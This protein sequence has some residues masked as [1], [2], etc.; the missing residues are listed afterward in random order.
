[1]D[2]RYNFQKLTPVNDVE[3]S[4]YKNALDF[5]FENPAIKNVGISGA[6]SAG[7]S[8]VI[9]TY[10]KLKPDVKFM[11]ISLAYF[12]SASD[13]DRQPTEQSE[14]V[15]EG[16]ILN[17]L[18][19]QI[20]PNKIPQTNFR[21]KRQLSPQKLWLSTAMVSLFTLLIIYLLNFGKWGDFVKSLTTKFLNQCLSFTTT[22]LTAFLAGGVCIAILSYLIYQII[23]VQFN[24]NLFKGIS[25]QG[26]TIEIFEQSEESYFDKYLN[27]VLYLFENS[28]K[29]VIVFED[30][31]RYNTNQI[32]Q[33]LREINTLVNS[34]KKETYKPLRFFYLLRD[35]IFINKER[36][37]FF[38]FIMP[39]VPILDGS[40]SF[41]QF[42]AHFKQ[43]NI[44]HLFNE[45]FLQ[46]ISLYIDDM[47]IL[48]NI[49]NEF[50]IYYKRISTTEQDPNRL[51]AIII[52]KNIF[53]RD[54]SE[55]QLNSGYVYTL[56]SK[57]D[58]FIKDEI[59][60][61][62]EE[63]SLITKTI[64]AAE[65]EHLKSVEEINDLFNPKIQDLQRY[66]NRQEQID[67]LNKE[68][69]SRFENLENKTAE[70]KNGLNQEISVL[71]AS[72]TD[73]QHKK[74]HEIINRQN[75]ERIFKV[76]YTNEIGSESTFNDIKGSDYFAL[77]KYL[78]KYGYIDETYP[79]YMTYFYE[80]S[81]SRIDKIFLRSVTDEDAKDYTY[82]LKSPEMVLARLS[83]TSFDKEEVLNFDLLAYLLEHQT[84]ANKNKTLKMLLQ[85]KSGKN[86]KFI[87][88][89]FGSQKRI[90]PFIKPLNN[91]WPD[92]FRAILEESNFTEEQKKAYA[93][94][95]IYHTAPAN[96]EE[97][98]SE[99]AL[100]NFVS[101]HKDFLDIAEPDIQRLIDVFELLNIKFLNINYEQ[102]NKELFQAVYQHNC[103]I[104]SYELV[105]LML[106]QIYGCLEES[107]LKHKNYTVVLSRINEPL[108]GYVQENINDYVK[109]ILKHC[110]GEILD[111]EVTAIKL[112]ND[113][114]LEVPLKFNYIDKLKTTICSLQDIEDTTLW[115]KLI[116]CNLIVYSESNVLKYFCCSGNDLD[117]T[118]ATFIN[119]KGNSFH[120][121]YDAIDSEFEKGGGSK[122]FNA[123]VKSEELSLKPY[124]SIL[125]SLSRHYKSFN[126]EGISDPKI[127]VLIDQ[128][129]ITMISQVLLFMRE[130][131]PQKIV[132]F[133]KHNIQEYTE[134][135]ISAENFSFDEM[136]E[137]LETNVDD[138]YKLSLLQH[139]D[140]PISAMVDAY[141]DEVKAYILKNNF[142]N[143]DIPKLLKAYL[144]LT[145]KLQAIVEDIARSHIEEIIENEYFVP[146]QL[147]QILFTLDSLHDESKLRLFAI[148]VNDFN[149]SE[150][151]ECLTILNQKEILSA[152]VGKRPAIPITDTNEKIL[153]ALV[154]KRW[155]LGYNVDK[156]NQNMYRI[157]SKRMSKQKSLPIEL[158]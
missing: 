31:D 149:E 89:Y 22:P 82:Q 8:S 116:V 66:Y 140:M 56:F 68:K 71:E 123:V 99:G 102:S 3:L 70:R 141:S 24:K 154:K 103:Y 151:K 156:N 87:S 86:F 148:T 63:I 150:C 59:A 126:I 72:I 17:Q 158:L 23:K 90:A 12:Q 47:R 1:M 138:E 107:D 16:K 94:E 54:F 117:K 84:D 105:C 42:I 136:C 67:A 48:K 50:L 21:V 29:D 153:D 2:N 15:L 93:L 41:D 121:D 36:T 108:G 46:E 51:L 25:V 79:D 143:N 120:F 129:I 83:L 127:E 88:L 14:N 142:D 133:I 62:R 34:R 61:L 69:S 115:S 114:I 98:D 122:F 49:Y 85:L 53:P 113:E 100:S 40:N 27:E 19:H 109:E 92:A 124:A 106:K 64:K 131:Y 76:T 7:K 32:F 33:R 55:P 74:L 144:S 81:L 30:M 13:S 6:Y 104:I 111:S 52:Y 11:H 78:I 5:V 75:A 147:C 101:T 96:L 28:D 39:V 119:K 45:H 20:E 35:D 110:E 97:V 18:I 37:K 135:V 65:N 43:G 132:N 91:V 80:H 26:N 58:D 57:K 112:L 155:I 152:F 10:K 157:S 139:T 128:G 4:I 95:S 125:K 145:E 9:E 146:M 137:I 118:L 130:H 134:D 77:I 38:D 73:L 44:F 60:R